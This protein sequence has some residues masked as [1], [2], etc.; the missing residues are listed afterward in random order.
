MGGRGINHVCRVA[1]DQRVNLFRPQL[2]R[3]AK[4]HVLSR[5]LRSGSNQGATDIV[6]SPQQCGGV[7]V[8]YQVSASYFADAYRGL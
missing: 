2:H 6:P 8:K 7:W 1:A 4:K 3:K 5:L